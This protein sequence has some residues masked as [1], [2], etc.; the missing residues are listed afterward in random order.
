MS[1]RLFLLFMLVVCAGQSPA[2]T[3]YD[4]CYGTSLCCDSTVLWN[5]FISR[6]E[7]FHFNNGTIKNKDLNIVTGTTRT[8]LA[9][10]SGEIG[11]ASCRE[12]VFSSV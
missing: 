11:R 10:K 6:T 9:N 3:L 8:Y 4:N 2:Q 5:Q 12:R 7:I 1:N